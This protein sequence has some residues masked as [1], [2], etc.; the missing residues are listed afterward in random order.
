MNI[1]KIY[2]V[3]NCYGDPNKVYIGK[4]KTNKQCRSREYFHQKTYGKN[5]KFTYIDEILSLE[6]KF[7]RPVERFWIEQFRQWGFKIQ[8]KNDGGGGVCYHS[9]ESKN[10]ISKANKG[11][12][13]ALGHKQSKE[14]RLKI[15]KALKGKPK[16]KGFGNMMRKVR[17][18]VPK[19]KGTGEKISKA[20][21]GRKNTTLMKKVIQMD[22]DG[23]FIK[24]W[25]SQLDAAISTNS[26]SSTISKV[27]RGKLKSTN[28][29]KWKFK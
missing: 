13:S 19:P 21:K 9:L 16:P 8:N 2:L 12:K 23:N 25:D 20:L 1:T 27:C 26:N 4:E 28:G 5:I 10:K 18:G 11:I 3:E 22:L 14:T 15:S 6:R 24:E 17:I 29:Y 7:W